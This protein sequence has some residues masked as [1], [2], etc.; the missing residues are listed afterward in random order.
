MKL[1]LENH[2]LFLINKC[3][4][5]NFSDFII[6]IFKNNNIN[7]NIHIYS[8]NINLNEE[9]EDI[10]YFSKNKSITIQNKL[11]LN[12][13]NFCY[14]INTNQFNTL[15]IIYTDNLIDYFVSQNYSSI[16]GTHNK[17]I[18]VNNNFNNKFQNINHC[19]NI[20]LKYLKDKLLNF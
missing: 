12:S 7:D 16:L 4:E 18:L 17:I 19:K 9:Q 8:N 20:Y 15:F 13:I 5:N 10:F 11:N 6:D 14:L 3:S 2:N 1:D